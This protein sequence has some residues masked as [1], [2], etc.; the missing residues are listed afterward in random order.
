MAT[1]EWPSE[2]H[3][4]LYKAILKQMEMSEK[5]TEEA[6][7]WYDIAEHGADTGWPGFTYYTD[8]TEFYEKNKEEI[9]ELLAEQA[10]GM[11]YTPI[12]L[13]AQFKIQSD[14]QT[15][16]TFENMMAWFALE[17]IARAFVD[18][19]EAEEDEYEDDEE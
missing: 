1:I 14:A 9:W 11:G 2:A 6:K 19:E 12:E 15:A 17:E 7:T 5:E 13:I 10:E 16:D 18:A 4:R 8:T 3:E